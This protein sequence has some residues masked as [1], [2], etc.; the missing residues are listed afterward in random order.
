MAERLSLETLEA[1]AEL[2][3]AAMPPTPQ[4]AW[5]LL[6]ERAG[7]ELWVKHENHTPIGAFKVRGGLVYM[8][9]LTRHHP[10]CPGVITATRGNHGQ[11]IGF[12]ARRHGLRATVLVPHGNSTEKNAAMR[13]FGVE[14]IEHGHDFQAAREEADRLAAERGLHFLGPFNSVLRR[15]TATYGL[16]LFRALPELDRVYVPIGMGSGL[17]GTIAA[18]DALGHRAEVI[19]VVAEQAPAYALS[20]D[21]GE[22]VT[23]ETADTLADGLACRV[24]DAEALEII[25]EGA[26]D[27]VQVSDAEIAA[28]MRA[29]YTD[30]HN[31]AE[32]AGAAALAAAL[33]DRDRCQGKQVAVV[34][35]GQNV[36]A[37]VFREVLAEA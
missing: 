4:Y 36:D 20:F 13:A 7:C 1:A 18:R 25:R 33:K 32:G 2:V 23:T 29:Y 35:C 26:A 16:E 28:A 10:D 17:T 34:L 22:V 6:A 11:S 15:G 27:I 37:R 21:R 14:L 12:A 5:P 9:W 31:V 3:H 24:P 19:G 30:T 8:D